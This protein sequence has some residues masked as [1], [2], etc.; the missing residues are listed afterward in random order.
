MRLGEF[1]GSG[2]R[3]SVWI[4]GENYELDVDMVIP[5]IS[6]Y[7]DFPFIGK[8]EVELTKMGYIR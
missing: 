3:R 2:R 7:A 4:E 6:Q 1:D 8:D 5:A